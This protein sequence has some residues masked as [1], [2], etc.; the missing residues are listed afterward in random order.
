MSNIHEDPESAWARIE[1]ESNIKPKKKEKKEKVVYEN[2]LQEKYAELFDEYGKY[3]H[4][5]GSVECNELLDDMRAFERV[6][7]I[8]KWKR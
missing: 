3:G 5:D 8:M 6:F 7:N 4:N 1:N 2:P